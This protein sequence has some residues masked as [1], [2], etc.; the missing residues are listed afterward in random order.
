MRTAAG[1]ALRLVWNLV[2]TV[3]VLGGTAAALI[4][5]AGWPL[6]RRWPSTDQ[7]TAFAEQP[8]TANTLKA[9]LAIC[10]W[11][12]W[13]LLVASI[14]LELWVRWAPRSWQLRLPHLIPQP[15]RLLA[16]GMLGTSAL[17]LATPAHAAALPSPTA[18]IAPEHPFA[19]HDTHDV[20]GDRHLRHLHAAD[21]GANVHTRHS[22]HLPGGWIAWPVAV[23]ILT[24]AAIALLHRRTLPPA[25]DLLRA[26][27]AARRPPID[28]TADQPPA[29]TSHDVSDI[30]EL[31]ADAAT[32]APL[33]FGLHGT[34]SIL[35]AD[36]PRS[37]VGLT[38]PGHADAL[39]GILAAAAAATTETTVIIPRPLLNTL[40]A[41]T[42]LPRLTVTTD[43][44]AA[45][46]TLQM[47]IHHRYL[48]SS[49][50]TAPPAAD[51]HRPLLLITEPPTDPARLHA[52]AQLG[53]EFN[54]RIIIAGHWHAGPT[55]TVD[56]HGYASHHRTPLGRLN[57]LTTAALHQIG[58]TLHPAH[59]TAPPPIAA[60]I[61][62]PAPTATPPLHLAVLGRP[63]LTT[64]TDPA[65][66]IRRS[67][68]QQIAVYLAL[69]PDGATRENLLELSFGH[70]R[71]AA[72]ATSLD[73]CLYELRRTL[74]VNGHRALQHIDHRYLLDPSL[75]SVDWWQLLRHLQA[76]QLCQAVACYRGPLAD[77][78][79]WD[80]LPEHRQHI[81]H[82]VADL[83]ARLAHAAS[84]PEQ[85]LHHALTGITVDPY[86]PACY[87]AAIDA[88]HH[89]G[90]IEQAQILQ[91]EMIRRLPPTHEHATT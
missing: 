6:P 64:P 19:P 39:R 84:T 80:W 16:A 62:P 56:P 41:A 66:H 23:G 9:A 91:A 26:I 90:N 12:L 86:S 25:T 82:L 59:Q 87:Q 3:A 15:L 34:T 52:L 55:W 72:A 67:G 78:H 74:T 4:W 70:M 17:T 69:H 35:L 27:R 49:H 10:G 2:I 38:G 68:S 5:W 29:D 20:D 79:A 71:A 28:P 65:T 14:L 31:E 33:T 21:P 37:G 11:L 54:V 30:A 8:L 45:L 83:H 75:I 53:A 36:L 58:H 42:H 89:L 60:P 63:T 57:V 77:G 24:A 81:R 46:H 7:W 85:A 1:A 43:V 51:R 47:Q 40:T 48:E 22:A 88:Y 76:G 73:S 32:T 61:P 44:T 50:T 13:L 18:P